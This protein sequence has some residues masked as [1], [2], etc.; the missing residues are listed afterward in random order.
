MKRIMTLVGSILGT[1][2]G[3]VA[4][5]LVLISTIAVLDLAGGADGVLT[6]ILL[7]VLPLLVIITSTILSA[8]AI[9]TWNKPA[10]KFK[11]K[12][13]LVITALVFNFISAI[14]EIA[15]LGGI[16]MIICAIVAIA[17]AV[18]LIVDLCL[19]GK[20]VEA[21]TEEEPVEATTEE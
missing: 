3:A 16:Y 13:G 18:L 4:S 2:A 20:R 12:K 19:E 17:S 7:L 1:V 8:I 6:L 14:L 21:T 5:I 10:D 9:A 15:L 11:A